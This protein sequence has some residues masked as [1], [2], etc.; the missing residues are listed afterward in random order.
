MGSQNITQGWVMQRDL[1]RQ[2]HCSWEPSC[3]PLPG[4]TSTPGGSQPAPSPCITCKVSQLG[5]CS[6]GLRSQGRKNRQLPT[7]TA[8][9]SL[10]SWLCVGQKAAKEARKEITWL[11]KGG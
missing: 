10:W 3:V 2:P 6:P 5:G 1:H 7:P 4:P 9:S 11:L 8:P